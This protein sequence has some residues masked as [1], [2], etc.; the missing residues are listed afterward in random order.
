MN[1]KQDKLIQKQIIREIVRRDIEEMVR[2]Y[3]ERKNV[4]KEDYN[5]RKDYSEPPKA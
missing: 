3:Q 4:L 2:M 1:L 5:F